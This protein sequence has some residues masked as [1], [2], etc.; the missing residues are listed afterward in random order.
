MV[1][2]RAKLELEFSNTKECIKIFDYEASI[3][4]LTNVVIMLIDAMKMMH[5]K[6]EGSIVTIGGV[7]SV[8]RAYFGIEDY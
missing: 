5:I 7:V 6:P 8:L 2:K 1:R 4:S 3:S